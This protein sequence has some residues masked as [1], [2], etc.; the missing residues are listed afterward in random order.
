[1][2]GRRAVDD[3]GAPDSQAALLHP[4][5]CTLHPAPCC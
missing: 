2:R 5:P 1:M 4:A 3:P